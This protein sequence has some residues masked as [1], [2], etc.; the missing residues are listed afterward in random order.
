MKLDFRPGWWRWHIPLTIAI[1]VAGLTIALSGMGMFQL[2]EWATLDRFFRLRPIEPPDSRIVIVGVEEEDITQLGQWPISDAMLARALKNLRDRHPRVI[3]LDIYR[4]LIVE[5]GHTELVEIFEST[6]NLIGVE[7]FSG[8]AVAP[9]PTLKKRDR[10]AMNDIVLDADGKVRRGLISSHRDGETKLSLGAK[11]ALMYLESEGI[12]PAPTGDGAIELGKARF[13]RFESNDG[14]YVGADAGGYQLLLNFRGPPGHF[15]TIALSD[16]LHDRVPAELIRDRIVLIGVTARSLNDFFYNPYTI[17]D[18]TTPAGVEIH[19]HLASAIVSAALDG[20]AAI[21]TFSDPVEGLWI[22]LWCGSSTMLGLLLPQR[23]KVAIGLVVAIASPMA[24]AYLAF[25]GGW[26]LPGLTPAIGA[27]CAAIVGIGYTLWNDLRHSHQ[28]LVTYAQT[29]EDKVRSRTITLERQT[30]ELARK[31]TQLKK[32]AKELAVARDT[33]EA[34]NRSKSAFLAHMSHELRTPLNAILGFS[35]LMARSTTLPPEHQESVRIVNRSGEHLLSLIENV[36]DFSKI[37]AGKIELQP[38]DFNLYRLLDDLEEMFSLHVRDKGLTLTFKIAPEVPEYIRVDKVKL[39]Q[40]LINT[41]GNGIKF[42]Q[43][44]GV[45]VEVST[46]R[47]TR[48]N[49]DR[50]TVCFAIVDTGLGIAPEELDRLFEPFI[51]TETGRNAG[52]GTG[53]GLAIVRQSIERMEGRITVESQVGVGTRFYFEIPVDVIEANTGEDRRDRRQAIALEVHGLPPR[54]LVADDRR[55][56]RLMLVEMLRPIGFEVREA[57]QGVE[58][59]EIWESWQ[60]DFIWMDARM[61]EMDGG[62]ATR[63][64]RGK[65]CA[66]KLVNNSSKPRKTAIVALSADAQ[67]EADERMLAAGCNAV[68]HKPIREDVVLEMMAQYLGIRYQTAIR[69]P[70]QTDEIGQPNLDKSLIEL[71]GILP[72]QW[73]AQLTHAAIA[74]DNDRIL[75]LLQQIPPEF[76]PIARQM[77]QWIGTFRCDRI[78][79]S[80]ESTQIGKFPAVRFQGNIRSRL[81]VMPSEWVTGIYWA[82][83]TGDD[84]RLRSL[85]KTMPVADAETAKLLLGLVAEFQFEAVMA[86]TEFARNSGGEPMEKQGI[87]SSSVKYS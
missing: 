69:S 22:F 14:G 87:I 58:A 40:I 51:Q 12:T 80:L 36:L 20:R 33:A 86:L 74:I 59:V 45:T 66:R 77:E 31:T 53:L 26:W 41:I 48:A 71:R 82:A 65:E 50:A 81:Q 67:I 21:D 76:A 79:E 17:N 72:P 46:T 4:D 28:Q 56:N 83:A 78:V 35:Q 47:T 34:A 60:P 7:K 62:E 15:E 32:Q 6:P 75:Q 39:R 25:L 29:L 43:A 85:I 3:G 11:L 63:I 37:E 9:P 23:K 27:L 68:T 52:Q 57:Q 49:G 8:D 44:G 61:P 54:V 18:A 10:V 2:L 19:A 30:R 38:C 42:V 64:I 24:M 73:F 70:I 16:L 55:D 5:P 1:S 13:T 84:D